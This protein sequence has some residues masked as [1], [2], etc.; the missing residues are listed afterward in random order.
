MGTRM[1]EAMSSVS[2]VRLLTWLSPS[3]PV[4][5][6]AYSHGLERAVHD[7]QV[8]NAEEL[9]AWLSHLLLRGSAW[10]DGVL[11]AEAWRRVSSGVGLS[12]IGDFAAALSGSLE[13][14]MESTLQGTAFLQAAKAWP[15]ETLDFSGETTPYCV[16]VGAVAGAHGVALADCLVAFLHG[17]AQN[18]IQAAIRLGVLGQTGGIGVLAEL[19]PAITMATERAAEATLED[20]GS[21]A[22]SPRS[23]RCGMKAST[24]GFFAHEICQRAVTRGDRRSGRGR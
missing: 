18:Q 11:L 3:F 17:F 6:F 12:D 8:G 4:G 5:A 10:N 22:F 16:A 9:R 7:G 21:S 19:E 24:R 14:H 13:R 20:L 23:R 15:C 1:A 2:L